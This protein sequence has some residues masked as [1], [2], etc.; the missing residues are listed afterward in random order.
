MV[1]PVLKRLSDQRKVGEQ[2]QLALLEV[3][4]ILERLSLSNWEAIQGDQLIEPPLSEA[5]RAALRDPELKV[6]T[7][8]G[9]SDPTARRVTVS[10][11][12]KNGAGE[13]VAPARLTAWT[14]RGSKQ[15]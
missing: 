11:R 5:C 6:S 9:E 12:W 8:N 1:V 7:T 4:D 2:R 15:K 3:S 13:F 10:L 14:Y